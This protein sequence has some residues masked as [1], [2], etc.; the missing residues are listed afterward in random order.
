M[1]IHWRVPECGRP[2]PFCPDTCV[3]VAGSHD[4]GL[5]MCRGSGHH[6]WPNQPTLFDL[7]TQETR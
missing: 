1:S 5:C 2:C 7:D 4:G 6:R 3:R